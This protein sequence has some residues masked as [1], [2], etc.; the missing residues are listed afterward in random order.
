MRMTKVFKIWWS[1]WELAS[2]VR[3]FYERLDHFDC[4]YQLAAYLC[5]PLPEM[6]YRCEAM[7]AQLCRIDRKCPEKLWQHRD[8]NTL[9]VNAKII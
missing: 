5:P 9:R 4:D 1:R 6:K 3:I 2:A 8:E 7:H